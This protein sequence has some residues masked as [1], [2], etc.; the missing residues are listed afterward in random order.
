MRTFP[1]HGL[2][3]ALI[4]LAGLFWVRPASRGADGQVPVTPEGYDYS[5]PRRLT[6]TLYEIGSNRTKVLYTF[7]RTASR[8][9]SDVKVQRQ[10]FSPGGSLAAEEDV[11]YQSNRL[12]SL[13]L[14]EFQAQVSGAFQ[15]GPDPKN[16]A[17][18]KLVIRYGPGLTPPANGESENLPPDTV[19]DDTLYPFMLSHWDNLMRGDAVKF[20]F[21]SL[22]WK[23]TF[24]FRLVKA[25][26]STE[27]G[28]TVEQIR[29]EPTGLIVARLV[30]PLVFRVEKNGA[31]RI[32]VYI[33]RTTPRIAKA[34]SWKYLDAET[35]FDWPD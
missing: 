28:R 9:G 26:E 30:K 23:R 17:R 5:A 1:F 13:R 33:G 8:S 3:T 14:Q 7:R 25:G 15:I 35:V 18:Q 34:K 16:P 12:V 10:F 24:V 22:E 19:C 32:L 29:M 21:I 31:H 20:H 4:L 27:N 6:A 2:G 11:A